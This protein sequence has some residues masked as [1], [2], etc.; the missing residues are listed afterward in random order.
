ML[1]AALGGRQLPRPEQLNVSI[2]AANIK[3]GIG[4][5]LSRRHS[6]F[7]FGERLVSVC[8]DDLIE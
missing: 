7:P 4:R 1:A 2:R 5:P 3:A 8:V 6:I